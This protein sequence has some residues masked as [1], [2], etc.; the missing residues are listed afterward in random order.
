MARSIHEVAECQSAALQIRQYRKDAGLSGI[1]P[2]IFV[3]QIVAQRLNN[4][5]ISVKYLSNLLF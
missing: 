2:A 3:A 4:P 5:E 1:K